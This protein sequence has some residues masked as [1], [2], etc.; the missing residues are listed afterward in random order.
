MSE[1]KITESIIRKE[2]IHYVYDTLCDLV[3]Q[4]FAKHEIKVDNSRCE[5][6]A[7]VPNEYTD[8]FYEEIKDKIADVISVNYKNAFF[9]KYVKTTGLTAVEKELLLTALISADVEEDKKYVFKKLEG[10]KDFAIDGI[11]NFRMKPLKEKWNEIAGYIPPTFTASDVTNFITY[12]IKDKKNKQVYVDNGEVYD[13]RYNL[14][15]RRK[16]LSSDGGECSVV[17]EILLSGAGVIKLGSPLPVE[18]EKYL[19]IFFG[20][21]ITFDK[22]YYNQ[23]N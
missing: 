8:I 12:L 14:L 21:R 13:R 1:I 9:K 6:I 4:M 10:F 7:D 22:G 15:K 2:N 5:Y 23:N 20:D 11:F 3:S 17:K 16:L 18:E 19:K